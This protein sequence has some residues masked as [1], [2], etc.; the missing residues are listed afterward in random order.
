ML[1]AATPVAEA[2]PHAEVRGF[3]VVR[4]ESS[5][6]IASFRDPVL[7]TVKPRSPRAIRRP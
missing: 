5:G 4:T 6:D 3:A 1:A 7:G 2:Y